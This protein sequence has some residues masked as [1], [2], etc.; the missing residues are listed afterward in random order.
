M[1]RPCLNNPNEFPD[2]AVL[3]RYLGGA[4]SAWD[5]FMAMLKDDYP[6]IAAEWRY[7]NDGKSWLCKVTRKTATVC[8]VAVRDK[9]FTAAF[10]LNAKA[11]PLV[12]ESS[13]AEALKDGFLHPDKE[14]KFRAIRVEVRK[15][16]DLHAIKELI[17]IKL[18]AK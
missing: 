8:W 1:D 17:E 2:A 3:A 11:E 16:S 18:K 9:F 12:R 15:K 5:A 13:L 4:K 14:S 10:Y 7:Y 6:Q